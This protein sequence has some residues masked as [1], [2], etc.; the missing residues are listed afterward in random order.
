M[1]DN[2]ISLKDR[3]KTK[4]KSESTD[5]EMTA[6]DL[7]AIVVKNKKNK[8]K[9]EKERLAANKNVLRSYRIKN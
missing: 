3:K 1:S 2:I 4:E 9:V 8:E 6:A 7:E 5:K